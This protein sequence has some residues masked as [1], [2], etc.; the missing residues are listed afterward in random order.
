MQFNVPVDMIAL[1]RQMNPGREALAFCPF[2]DA[3]G[4]CEQK[5]SCYFF[6]QSKDCAT[7]IKTGI[8]SGACGLVHSTKRRDYHTNKAPLPSEVHPPVA[9]PINMSGSK[10][11]SQ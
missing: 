5:D 7:W 2:V 3:K 8:C 11:H 1:L 9:A 10:P 6:H 4:N